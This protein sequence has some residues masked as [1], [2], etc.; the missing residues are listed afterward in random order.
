MYERKQQE[1]L[2][3]FKNQSQV[4]Q[5]YFKRFPSDHNFLN[6]VSI[7]FKGQ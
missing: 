7:T 4:F 3:T 2:E 5:S 6:V 1:L